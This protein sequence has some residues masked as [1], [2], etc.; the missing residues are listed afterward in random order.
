VPQHDRKFRAATILKVFSF[1][2]GLGN[3]KLCIDAKS[4]KILYHAFPHR[5]R[6]G[7]GIGKANY[8]FKSTS[9]SF[10]ASGGYMMH[11]YKMYISSLLI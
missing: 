5:R 10:P 6:Q 1:L 4:L 2:S 11:I 7:G 3:V 8:L 9:F